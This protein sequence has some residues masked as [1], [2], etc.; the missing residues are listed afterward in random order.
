MK[1]PATF[2]Q[3]N[4]ANATRCRTTTGAMPEFQSTAIDPATAPMAV[5]P[6]AS[7]ASGETSGETRLT[8]AALVAQAETSNTLMPR[9]PPLRGFN[10]DIDRAVWC[11]DC[12]MYLNT[13]LFYEEHLWGPFHRKSSL[14]NKKAGCSQQCI[15][16][17]PF[18][19]FG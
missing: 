17:C 10:D 14:K 19:S 15:P 7:E 9:L 6:D 13:P 3:G 4:G 1:R 18:P 5:C 16:P 11:E 2:P 8:Y 12:R